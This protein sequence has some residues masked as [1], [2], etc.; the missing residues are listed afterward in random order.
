MAATI[1]ETESLPD[2]WPVVSGNPIK[3][4]EESEAA[5]IWQRIEAWTAYRW[6]EREVIWIAEGPG[7]W[8]PPLAP[9]A[10]SAVEIWSGSGWVAATPDASPL[11]GYVL[12][13]EGPYRITATV[14]GGDLPPAVER[15]FLRVAEYLTYAKSPNDPNAPLSATQYSWTGEPDPDGRTGGTITRPTN[16]IA[17]ALINSGA[18]DLLRPYRRAS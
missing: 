5:Y 7:E 13:C 10:V 12:D 3:P 8:T 18:A 11:G 6:T 2:A 9:A 15:A 4:V 14:G 17:K 1:K 16:W